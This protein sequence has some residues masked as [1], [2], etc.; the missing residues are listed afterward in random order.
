MYGVPIVVHKAWCQLYKRI[1]ALLLVHFLLA[2]PLLA[3][4]SDTDSVAIESKF[5]FSIFIGGLKA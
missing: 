5:N 4:N 2:I 3:V 1:S